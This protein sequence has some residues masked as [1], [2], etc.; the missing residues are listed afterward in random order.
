MSAL[1]ATI[2][3]I[4]NEG[5]LNIVEFNFLGNTLKMMSLDLN[6]KVKVGALVS[7]DIKPTQIALAK[8]FEGIVSFSN[9]IKAKVTSCENGKLLS[10]IQLAI[11]DVNIESIITAKSSKKMNIQEN[12]ELTILIKASDLS[13]KE[14]LS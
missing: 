6:Q 9:Q 13:I 3:S 12:D 1:I 5:N 14:V 7:L 4:E 10:S 2:I 8:E 11:K